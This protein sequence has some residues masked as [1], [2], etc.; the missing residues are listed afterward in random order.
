MRSVRAV[1][2]VLGLLLTACGS[3]STPAGKSKAAYVAS[4]KA[5]VFHRP[6]CERAQKISTGNLVTY[7]TREKAVAAGK[8]PCK[9][10]RP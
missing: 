6:N 2:V 8:R 9:V 4:T 5:A 1:V 10:C 7:E 3:S